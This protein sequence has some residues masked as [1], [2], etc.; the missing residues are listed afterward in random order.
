MKSIPPLPPATHS[1]TYPSPTTVSSTST[2][3]KPRGC[4]PNHSPQKDFLSSMGQMTNISQSAAM[5]APNCSTPS[6]IV[7]VHLLRK[8]RRKGRMSKVEPCDLREME[9]WRSLG[10]QDVR[11]YQ[12]VTTT[13]VRAG[14]FEYYHVPSLKPVFSIE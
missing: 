2:T 6:R 1:Q 9:T 7:P 12:H 10:K 13:P 14:I 3:T 11:G 5:M 8:A 4:S